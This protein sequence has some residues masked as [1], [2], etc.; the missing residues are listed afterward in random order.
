MVI[1]KEARTLVIDGYEYDITEF[2][3]PGGNVINYMTGQDASAPFKEFHSRSKKVTKYLNSLPKKPVTMD[4]EQVMK[5]FNDWR[6]DLERRGFFEPSYLH[7]SF[8][9]FELALLFGLGVYFIPINIYLSL[10]FFMLFG[11]RSGWVQHEG[12]HNSLTGNMKVDK[13]LQNLTI[14]FGLLTDGAMWNS[15]HNKHHATPQK[16]NYDIDLDTTPLVA[17]FNNAIEKNRTGTWSKLWLKY[18]AWT[19]LPVTSGLLVMLFWIFFLHPRKVIRDKNISQGIVLLFGHVFRTWLFVHFGGYSWLQAYGL[20]MISMWGTGVYLF[21][22]F[23]LSHTFT[24]VVEENENVNWVQYAVE[25]SIDIDPHNPMINWVMG[26]LNC[27]VIHHLFPTMPQYKQPAISKELMQLTKKW[28][29]K[30]EVMGYWEAWYLM[31]KNLND[32][33]HQYAVDSKKQA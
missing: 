12:G 14:G 18:Q 25:H 2:K 26:Y 6:I 30:Y 7:V 22:H 11:G 20:L 13:L 1:A 15:M 5:E 33:G 24:P 27:Q 16:V 3:H 4:K 10:T 8:R 32:V 17:F 9:I 31:F 21:G 19:F 29:M 23:S 28:G